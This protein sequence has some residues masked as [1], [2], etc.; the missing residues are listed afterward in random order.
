M[1]NSLSTREA[2]GLALLNMGATE[3]DIVVLDADLSGSTNTK[4][5]AE[6]FPN[7]FFN[8]G[9]A[10]QNLIG[11]AAGLAIGG[12]TAFAGTFAMFLMRGWEQIRNTVAHDNLNVKLLAS[13]S[14]LTNSKDGGSHQCLEDIALMSCLPNMTILNPVDAI[15]AEKIVINEVNRKGPSY[16][17]M[18]R[19]TTPAINNDDY[20]FEFGKAIE[21]REGDDL[22]IVATGTM[23]SEAVKASVMLK[24]EN[25]NAR[26]LNVHTI[27]PLDKN[28]ILRSAK[29]TGHIITIEEHNVYGG[30][31][32]AVAGLIVEN[33]PVPMK[34]M[35]VNDQFGESGDYNYLTS[36]FG[37]N[38]GEIIKNAKKLIGDNK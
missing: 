35:G 8:V 22:T 16:I 17:R 20:E 31:G 3:K 15:E 10:E 25:I 33:Y 1:D 7:R 6:K 37:L 19:L 14:G 26:V 27:K 32:S 30:L 12:K 36:K 21:I 11:T 13:H 2:C 9:C 34:V 38:D 23:V 29:E 24:K 5:F 18:N 4:K 28:S